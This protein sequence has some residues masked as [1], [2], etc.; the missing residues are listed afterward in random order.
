MMLKEHGFAKLGRLVAQNVAQA[1]HLAGLVDAQPALERVAPVPLNVVCFRYRGGLSEPAALDA[2]N[3]E[4]VVRLHESG[5]AAPSGTLVRGSYAV[6]AAITN[7]RS[8]R[9][10]FRILVDACLEIGREL[11][12]AT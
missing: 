6:R 1:R 3:R 11:E 9:D 8:R 12:K 2:L 4:L 5:I 10:D 7:H